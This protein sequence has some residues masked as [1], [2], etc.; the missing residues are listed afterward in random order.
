MVKNLFQ[1]FLCRLV[2][3]HSFWGSFDYGLWPHKA[4]EPSGQVNIS[5]NK[6]LVGINTGL[7]LQVVFIRRWSLWHVL[8]KL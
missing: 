7:F 4:N 6:Q 5:E 3:T 8:L 2:V 1:Q